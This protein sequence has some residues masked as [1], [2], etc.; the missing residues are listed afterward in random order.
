MLQG[1]KSTIEF[2]CSR[3]INILTRN[4][5]HQKREWETKAREHVKTIEGL[6]EVIASNNEM[7]TKWK[8]ELR[9]MEK[10]VTEL[11]EENFAIVQKNSELSMNLERAF[12][13][14]D[15]YSIR[16]KSLISKSELEST[17]QKLQEQAV[18]FLQREAEILNE[19][20]TLWAKLD[21]SVIDKNRITRD[22]ENTRK[23]LLEAKEQILKLENTK[24]GYELELRQS[25]E[26]IGALQTQIKRLREDKK[27]LRDKLKQLV[28]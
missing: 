25:Q 23:Q 3:E 8:E 5:E 16:E 12:G 11:K 26:T 20:K 2:K 18:S 6:K 15:S 13:E 9:K 24:P 1:I 4:Y 17:E 28:W 7:K 19:Q 27:K 22:L 10:L 21:Q 14:V